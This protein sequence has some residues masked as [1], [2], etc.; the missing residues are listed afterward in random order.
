MN[1]Q[2]LNINERT[3]IAQL[4]KSKV[5]IREIARILHR[6]PSTISQ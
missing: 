6:S 1:Y 3:V 4:K 5:S 2:H